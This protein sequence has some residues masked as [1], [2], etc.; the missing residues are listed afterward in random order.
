[1]VALLMA[2][3][4][5]GQASQPVR[6]VEKVD[7]DRYLGDWFEIARYPNGFQEKCVGDVFEA[8]GRTH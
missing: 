3:S 6:T 4:N 7:L 2:V 8:F 5:A 1:M